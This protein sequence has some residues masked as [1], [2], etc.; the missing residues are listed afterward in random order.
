MSVEI[1]EVKSKKQLK[2]FIMLPFEMHKDHEL[3]VPPLIR[4]EKHYVDPKKNPH[5][6]YSDTVCYL[7]YRDNKPV[8]RIMGIINHRLID[9]WKDPHAR[10]CNFESIND[11]EVAHVLLSSIEKWALEHGMKRVVGPLGFSNQDPQ[12]FIIE[13][14]SE[15]PS[16]GTICNFEYIPKLVENEG[17]EKEVDYVTYKIMLPREIPELYQK[18]AD[19]VKKR[20]NVKLLEFK[21]KRELK[22]ILPDVLRFMNETY[23]DIY[24]FIPLTEEVI[25]KATNNYKEIVDPEFLKVIVNEKNEIVS[26]I[27]GI[28]DITEGFKKAKGR[29]IP[30]GYFIIKATQKKSNRLD[31]LLGA[32]KKEYRGKGLDTL[33]MIAMTRSAHKLGMEYADSHHELETNTRVQ[34]EMKRLGGVIYKRHRVYRKFL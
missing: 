5:L 19:R 26:F 1:I 4:F 11:Q 21:S 13:G 32:I 28:K 31:L 2:E 27:L 9:K 23:V 33:M 24:G 29:L 12:G 16:I 22:K 6:K 15:R 3:W 17:Y 8:G 25:Q 7:V 14:F 20:M 30:F 10:F 34:A 18:I